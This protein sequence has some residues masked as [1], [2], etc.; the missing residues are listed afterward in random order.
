MR[1]GRMALKTPKKVQV[2]F[3][4]KELELLNVSEDFQSDFEGIRTQLIL[5]LLY[6]TGMRRAELISLQMNSVD[7][8]NGLVKVI[9]KRNKERIIPVPTETLESLTRYME[10]RS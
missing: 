4:E 3:S 2:P 9:G 10:H 7:Y 1:P 5:D 8:A 6:A